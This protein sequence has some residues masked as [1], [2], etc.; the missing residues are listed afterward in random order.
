[1]A[2]QTKPTDVK[3]VPP[4]ERLVWIPGQIEYSP[5][6]PKGDAQ[7]FVWKPGDVQSPDTA[8]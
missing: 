1:M 3:P 6:L 7:R 5:P 8:Q 2:D 4:E